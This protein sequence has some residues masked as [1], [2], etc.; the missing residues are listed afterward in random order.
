MAEKVNGERVS[1]KGSTVKEEWEE[2]GQHSTD[3]EVKFIFQNRW[4][5]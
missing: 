4:V 1:C 5:S 2:K 3:Q